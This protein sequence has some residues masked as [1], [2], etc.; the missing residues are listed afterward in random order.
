[1]V[2]CF[3]LERCKIRLFSLRNSS[4]LVAHKHATLPGY[5]CMC[6]CLPVIRLSEA[7]SKNNHRRY[8]H[9]ATGSLHSNIDA[10]V[11]KVITAFVT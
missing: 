6:V 2:Y 8:N 1:M 11:E 3:K 4:A 5:R 7:S 9:V 10:T